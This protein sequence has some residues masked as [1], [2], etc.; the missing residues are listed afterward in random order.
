MEQSKS[1]AFCFASLKIAGMAIFRG[2][3][4]RHARLNGMDSCNQREVM[5]ASLARDERRAGAATRRRYIRFQRQCRS[6]R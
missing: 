1:R 6:Q 3:F 2:S 5:T 4:K